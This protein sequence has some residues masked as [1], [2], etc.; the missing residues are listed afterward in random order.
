MAGR[1]TRWGLIG[2]ACF[3]CNGDGADEGPRFP[4]NLVHVE[5]NEYPDLA[6]NGV[7]RVGIGGVERIDGITLDGIP[8]PL[9][10][11]ERTP[12]YVNAYVYRLQ[13]SGQFAPGMHTLRAF[14][15]GEIT[16]PI[17]LFDAGFPRWSTNDSGFAT[18]WGDCLGWF[19]AVDGVRRVCVDQIYI[20]VEHFVRDPAAPVFTFWAASHNE[21]Y[22]WNI[23]L[24]GLAM[25]RPN[26]G[27]DA[28]LVMIFNGETEGTTQIAAAHPGR[29]WPGE[30]DVH[31]VATIPRFTG[32]G[33]VWHHGDREYLVLAS[34]DLVTAHPWNPEA[35]TV[36]QEGT[37]VPTGLGAVWTAVGVDLD[38]DGK[39]ELV[40]SKENGLD[41]V[42]G[43]PETGW[44]V[45]AAVS[46]E[47]TCA[48]TPRQWRPSMADLDGDGMLDVACTRYGGGIDVIYTNADGTF[49]VRPN[50]LD[51]GCETAVDTGL[52]SATAGLLDKDRKPYVMA[53]LGEGEFG[54]FFRM[55]GRG[56]FVREDF[57]APLQRL[58]SWGS[59]DD[60]YDVDGDGCADFVQGM[61][62]R[63]SPWRRPA[64]EAEDGLF[65]PRK[66]ELITGEDLLKR[67]AWR[68]AA[69]LRLAQDHALPSSGPP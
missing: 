10:E 45:V 44:E 64:Y 54:V 2:V 65:G 34:P 41:I 4:Y 28:V 12:G 59:N 47:G 17:P 42:R 30:S 69:R 27:S 67:P 49:D 20:R 62:S 33:T 43:A 21:V 8:L 11:L 37:R 1:V 16:W 63:I 25:S 23:F 36:E 68:H 56:T 55:T 66:L 35:L 19:P 57:R 40:V 14:G 61:R 48:F 60:L 32:G 7:L 58:T 50:L 52:S 31:A 9:D 39:D 15:D 38:Q 3:A 51:P 22:T 29:W 46:G 53:A 26:A 13:L 24:P 6:T 5:Q 18:L